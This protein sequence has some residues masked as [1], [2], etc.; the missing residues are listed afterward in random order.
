M[1]RISHG[2]GLFETAAERG[3][4]PLDGDDETTVADWTVYAD[5]GKA[6]IDPLAITIREPAEPAPDRSRVSPGRP[7][8]TEASE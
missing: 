5:L 3:C 1:T 4:W 7:P 2:L 6:N 8:P